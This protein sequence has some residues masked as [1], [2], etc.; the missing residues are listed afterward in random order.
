MKAAFQARLN[1]EFEAA[2]TTSPTR[3]TGWTAAGPASNAKAPNQRGETAI[4]PALMD[5]VGAALTRVPDFDIHKH[6]RAPARTKAEMFRT[7]EGF[8]WATAE[9]LAFGSLLAEGYPVRLAGQDSTRGTF[10]QRHSPSSTRKPRS[11][12]TP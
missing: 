10:S 6:G 11:G 4:P 1:A 3:P 9:A 12:T 8:D 2:K 7:G 5:E